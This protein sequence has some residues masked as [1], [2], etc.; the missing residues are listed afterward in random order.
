MRCDRPAGGEIVENVGHDRIG[1]P[2]A[3]DP[4][5]AVAGCSETVCH[6]V[7]AIAV[8]LLKPPRPPLVAAAK[9]GVEAGVKSHGDRNE[10]GDR[11][12]L[13]WQ[14][15]PPRLGTEIVLSPRVGS[16]ER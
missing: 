6:I 16:E 14:A 12:G 3:A 13:V 11:V 15:C 8:F 1:V 4:V 10:A 5:D 9:A 2:I 7:L